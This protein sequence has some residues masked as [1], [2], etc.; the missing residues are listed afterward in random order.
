MRPL[1][2]IHFLR[3]L[4][5]LLFTPVIFYRHSEFS[6]EMSHSS[7]VTASTLRDYSHF[8]AASDYQCNLAEFDLTKFIIPSQLTVIWAETAAVVFN[9]GKSYFKW[10]SD[11]SRRRHAQSK[12]AG[13][14]K[15]SPISKEAAT[16][17]RSR[18]RSNTP[19]RSP[20]RKAFSPWSDAGVAAPRRPSFWA[21]PD[22]RAANR[23]PSA[24]WRWQRAGSAWRRLPG[25]PR[26][27]VGTFLTSAPLGKSFSANGT[28]HFKFTRKFSDFPN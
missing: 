26:S 13:N 3:L 11:W 18:V 28:R 20:H 7:Q 24:P 17:E 10:I 9:E 12:T 14:C 21:L 19:C 15:L 2:Q 4:I 16:C 22:T 1:G 6:F 5:C 8:Y 23:L 25:G 27:G